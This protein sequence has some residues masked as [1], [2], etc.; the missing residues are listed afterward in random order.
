MKIIILENLHIHEQENNVFFERTSCQEEHGLIGN[1]DGSCDNKLSIEYKKEVFDILTIKIQ[2]KEISI[3]GCDQNG[4][5]L[6]STIKTLFNEYLYYKN[7]HSILSKMYH[8]QEKE[9]FELRRKIKFLE[10]M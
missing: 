6:V 3:T 9:L 10:N 7:A 8:D 5:E 2:N 1:F 4:V